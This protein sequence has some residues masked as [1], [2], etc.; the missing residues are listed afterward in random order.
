MKVLVTGGTGNVG[1]AAVQRLV[2]HGHQ[3]TVI[4]RRPDIE[5][6]GAAYR[7][8]DITDFDTLRTHV[9]GVEGI[10]HLAAIPYPG[11]A[12]GEEVF[13][14]NCSGTYNVY[15]AAAD[16]GVA[17]IASASSINAL[18]Y[19]YGLVSFPIR[20]FPIDE[21]HPTHTT[22]SYSFSKQV[23]EDIGDYFWRR[24]GVS[25]VNLR[26]PG[27]YEYDAERWAHMREWT[28]RFRQTLLEL[29]AAPE[30]ERRAR[31]RAVVAQ[32]DASRPDRSLPRAREEMRRRRAAM[33][34]DP[35]MTLLFGGFGRS[36]FWAS[37][38][39][40]DS[41]QALEQGL[42]A[43]YRGSHALFVNDNHNA[44]GVDSEDLVQLFFPEV[45]GRSHPLHGT[46]TLVS[47]DRARAVLGFEPEHSAREWFD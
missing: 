41:A 26:L 20:Y 39:A 21:D 31:V 47:I 15:R 38:D 12:P 10:V 1:R 44:A 19:N 23:V 18:G 16:Q 43:D 33:R 42:L 35:D 46:E 32:F 9:R 45:E 14:V 30:A 29:F 28:A 11:G 4:G 5:I 37:I 40:R 22:D 24:E 8:C 13:R 17:K 34:E 27:V 25:S 3:V 2:A 36:N 7:R 6:E